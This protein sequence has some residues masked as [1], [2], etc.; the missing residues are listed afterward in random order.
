MEHLD[1]EE[2]ARDHLVTDGKE[3]NLHYKLGSIQLLG[4]DTFGSVICIAEV[5]GLLLICIPNS[6][7]HK[8]SKDKKLL[9]ASSFK[10]AIAVSVA[11]V[12]AQDRETLVEDCELKVWIGLLSRESERYL[13]FGDGSDYVEKQ[14]ET[15]N[16]G[17]GFLPYAEALV[18]AAA[19]HFTFLSAE[20]EVLQEHG[21]L[22]GPGLEDRMLRVEGALSD[23]QESLS[24]LLAGQGLRG[25]E[26]AAGPQQSA[27]AKSK[28]GA[29]E[30]KVAKPKVSFEGLEKSV[31]EAA[32]QAGIEEDHLAEMANIVRGHPKRMEDLP[33]PG[34]ARKKDELSESEDSSEEEAEA[35]SGALGSGDGGVA[36][37]IVKLT[38][39]CSALAEGKKR[40]SDGIESLLDQSQL[41]TSSDGSGLGSGRKNAQALRALKRCLQENP[42]YIYKTIESNLMTDF[43]SRVHRPGDP[44]GQ[45]SVRGWLE[46]RSRI[47]NYTNHVRWSWAVGGIWDDLI[48]ER[49]GSARARAALLIAASDQAAI[50]SGSWLLSNVSLLENQ[51]PYQSF[52][53]H[54][55]PSPQD[56]QHSAL[57]DPRW[58]ELF[59]SHVKELDSYQE[60]RK[61]LAKP[62]LKTKPEDPPRPPKTPKAKPKAKGGGR[63]R[64]SP[65]G[66]TA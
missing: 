54:Q 3:T 18:G 60:A 33:R 8:K 14:F 35:S 37:A 38:K 22:D 25:K 13:D 63:E 52:A 43:T 34:A 15:A 12:S 46:S 10:K 55:V 21:G 48:Q 31:V 24:A 61:K 45:A 23:I 11:G 2:T 1:L 66:E 20:E 57:W 17:E 5:E 26:R 32:L 6:V 59:L 36:K 42:E 7:W 39:V 47:L 56:L 62:A 9:P 53:S 44:M 28:R 29:T 51:P 64:D 49:Y 27:E 4:H 19:E 40:R 58:F 65:E 41:G 16:G 30:K 50:D